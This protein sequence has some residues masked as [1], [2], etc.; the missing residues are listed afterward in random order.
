MRI[1]SAF[2]LCNF[3][4]CAVQVI[5]DTFSSKKYALFAVIEISLHSQFIHSNALKSQESKENLLNNL[6]K[7]K[8]KKFQQL[9]PS[10][11]TLL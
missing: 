1:I 5:S 3:N 9:I 7:I 6:N 8:A 10:F 11:M 2:F 4:Q